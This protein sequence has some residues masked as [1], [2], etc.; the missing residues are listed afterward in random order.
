ML[1]SRAWSQL[2]SKHA[3]RSC[4]Q[5]VLTEVDHT[6]SIQSAVLA[7]EPQAQTLAEDTDAA[8]DDRFM[9]AVEDDV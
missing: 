1:A 5:P 6:A 7:A 4:R 2:T 9:A 3:D 8:L